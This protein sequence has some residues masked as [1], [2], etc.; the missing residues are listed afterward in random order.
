MANKET[1]SKTVMIVNQ[2]GLHARAAA[3]LAK[4][5]KEFNC[6]I[7]ISHNNNTACAK[8]ILDLLT[9]AAS[10]GAQVKVDAFNGNDTEPALKSVVALVNNGF[11]E[12]QGL[13][14]IKKENA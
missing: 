3:K 11:E 12:D 14:P 13:C 2:R 1:Q 6:S 9:L 4:L 8:D 7:K 10:Q 5:A